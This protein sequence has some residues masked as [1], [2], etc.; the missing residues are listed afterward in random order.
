MIDALAQFKQGKSIEKQKSAEELAKDNEY[1]KPLKVSLQEQKA[2]LAESLYWSFKP[3]KLVETPKLWQNNDGIL[4]SSS[5]KDVVEQEEQADKWE[6]KNNDLSIQDQE[7]KESWDDITNAN[8]EWKK[9]ANEQEVADLS[10]FKENPNYPILERF[11]KI[12]WNDGKILQSTQL[13]NDELIQISKV[14]DKNQWDQDPLQYLKE[15]LWSVDFKNSDTSM[16]LSNYIDNL[17][18]L[19]KDKEADLAKMSKENDTNNAW[20]QKLALPKEFKE[21]DVLNNDKSD[22]V[23]MLIKNHT[24]LP[25]KNWKP[26]FDKDILTTFEVTANKVINWKVIP[27]NE[28]F[29]L[30]M[31]DVKT[32]D[33]ETRMNALT[34]LNTIVNNTEWHKSM[35]TYTENA[36]E[37]EIVGEEEIDGEI[38]KL[39]E[40][41][42][43]AQNNWDNV[44]VKEIEEQIANLDDKKSSWEVFEWGEFDKV[45]DKEPTITK[46]V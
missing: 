33:I 6:E 37:E 28:S 41:L 24:K 12:E 13:N 38:A 34:Y 36:W 5:I 39:N 32:W 27:R 16:Y 15:N 26:N 2:K 1:N 43:E 22:I 44:K 45:S 30:A 46:N 11:T 35:P 31:H 8:N 7:V 17:L 42:L 9:E 29:E 25:D 18:D 21:N 20:E 19:N 14:L 40:Q 10:K 4:D 23:Q 3:Q